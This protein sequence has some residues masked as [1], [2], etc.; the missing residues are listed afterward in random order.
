MGGPRT[1]FTEAYAQ[2]LSADCDLD[3]EICEMVLVRYTSSYCAIL[4]LNP[5]MQDEVIGRTRFWNT[6]TQAH[7][8][9]YVLSPF[10]SGDIKT[11]E[12]EQT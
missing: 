4:C 10:Y 7:T 8:L 11:S 12:H 9:R 2:S 3:L 5:T 6:H 1:G